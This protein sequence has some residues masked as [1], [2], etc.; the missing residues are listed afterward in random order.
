LGGLKSGR[1]CGFVQH[2]VGENENVG[3]AGVDVKVGWPCGATQ[4]VHNYAKQDLRRTCRSY[5]QAMRYLKGT[6][7][8]TEDSARPAAPGYRATPQPLA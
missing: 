2:E 8:V 3:L 6:S 1:E 7:A 5:A 4:A